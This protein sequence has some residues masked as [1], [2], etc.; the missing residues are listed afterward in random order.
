MFSIISSATF[1]IRAVP[2]FVETDIASGIPNFTI[3][4]LPD[5]SVRESRDRIRSAMRNSGFSFPRGRIT[6]NLAP[7]HLRKQG[8]VY[9]LAI[10]VSLLV[11]SGLITPSTSAQAVFLGEL[12]LQGEVRPIQGI[13]PSILMAKQEEKSIVFVPKEN[14]EEA[15]LI[16]GVCVYGVRTLRELVDHLLN[17]TAIKSATSKVPSQQTNGKIDFS[18]IRGHEFAKRG[19]EIAAAGG[20]NVLLQGPP[21]TGKTMLAKAFVSLLPPLNEQEAIEA[22]CIASIAGT[23][24]ETQVLSFTRPFRAPHHSSSASALIGGGVWPAPG[25][26][27][28]AHHGVLFLDELPE[29]SRHALETLRQP[30]EDGTVTIARASG[31]LTFPARFQLL[32]TRNPCPC[33]YLNDP[34]RACQCDIRDIDRYQRRI[35][36]PLLDRIDLV[37]DVPNIEIKDL[38]TQADAQ[39]SS[40]IHERVMKSIQYRTSRQAEP[41]LTTEA[42]TFLDQAFSSGML[43]TRGY[44]RVQKTASTIAD[45]AQSERIEERHLAEALQYRNRSKSI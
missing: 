10:A 17:K 13:L 1:G 32:A 45:L 4:G 24:S 23:R 31:S 9:D 30:M 21:G 16:N 26:A 41:T 35:S 33:G 19:L 7:A 27:S 3:V 12:G 43:S 44:F 29:F 20:H 18:Q 40:V 6:V 22:A 8:A 36:G 14:A 25:E 34:K 38:T 39:S 42:K 11:R 15:A 37:I 28:L 2:V 5:T